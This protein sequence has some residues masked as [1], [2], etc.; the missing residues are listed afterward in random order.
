MPIDKWAKADIICA[1]I[2]ITSLIAINTINESALKSLPTKRIYDQFMVLIIFATWYRLVMVLFIM[3]EYSVLLMTIIKMMGSVIY[4]FFV[5]LYY[6]FMAALVAS[7]IFGNFPIYKDLKEAMRAMFD[8]MM[9]GHDW[10]GLPNELRYDPIH[11][12]FWLLHIYISHIFLLNYLVAI[13]ATVYGE[14]QEVGIFS[15]NVNRYQFIER[16]N[17]AFQDINGYFELILHAPPINILLVS[18][19][20]SI[21]AADKMQQ[22][23]KVFSVCMFWGE[24]L[25]IFI[26]YQLFKEVILIPWNYLRT[27]YYILERGKGILYVLGWML[28]GPFYLTYCLVYD[29]FNFIKLLCDTK[30]DNEKQVLM[31][32]EDKKQNLQV[33]YN[34]IIDVIKCVY[35]IFLQ[36]HREKKMG[37]GKKVPIKGD[38]EV[39]DA[40]R[41]QEEAQA[42]E[43]AAAFQDEDAILEGYTID[44][45]FILQAWARYRPVQSE[46]DINADSSRKKKKR[47]AVVSEL[48]ELFS[49]KF[50]AKLLGNLNLK[51]YNWNDSEP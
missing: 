49:D 40:I 18:I 37:K 8:C 25:V 19:L 44:Y 29:M 7:G 45:H 42:K 4:F 9:G 33:M 50:I 1:L 38:T 48:K 13:L 26:P 32:I 21:F 3:D 5:L 24:N 16:Y 6:L 35:F 51:I 43:E 20:P 39:G 10:S 36:K 30:Q 11:I 2:N 28:V 27:M 41:L 23:Q 15:W 47:A 14:M 34:E 17:I 12:L 46:T 31:D 22:A